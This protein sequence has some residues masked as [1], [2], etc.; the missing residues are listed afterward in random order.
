MS[1]HDVCIYHYFA[2]CMDTTVVIVVDH[3]D[4]GEFCTGVTKPFQQRI[5]LFIVWIAFT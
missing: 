1:E 2:S 4:F 5:V 3:F